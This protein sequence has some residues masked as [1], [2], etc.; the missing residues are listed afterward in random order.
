M[1]KPL[2][3]DVTLKERLYLLKIYEKSLCVC[4]GKMVETLAGEGIPMRMEG[5]S[6]ICDRNLMDS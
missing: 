5:M 3:G 6:W 1:L 4:A 2:T